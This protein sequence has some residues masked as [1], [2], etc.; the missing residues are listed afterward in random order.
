MF[1]RIEYSKMPFSCR[2]VLVVTRFCSAD[3]EIGDPSMSF[4]EAV[5][6]ED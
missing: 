5:G 4:T 2:L 1:L 3:F 6:I